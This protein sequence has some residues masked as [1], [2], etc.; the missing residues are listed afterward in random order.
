MAHDRHRAQLRILHLN[1]HENCPH[2]P[3]NVE[4]LAI[5]LPAGLG[6][7]RLAGVEGTGSTK[8]E[9]KGSKG[10]D[11]R[12]RVV[13][14]CNGLIAT[15]IASELK[16]RIDDFSSVVHPERRTSSPTDVTKLRI[17]GQTSPPRALG[18]PAG[19]IDHNGWIPISPL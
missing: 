13:T 6:D 17:D 1:L 15:T 18:E 3:K 2:K 12:H 19:W 16:Q 5:V 7:S 4:F 8:A 10:S 9:Q 11:R 14:K